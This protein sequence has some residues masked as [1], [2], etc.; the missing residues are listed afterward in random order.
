[1]VNQ[2]ASRKWPFYLRHGLKWVG[3]SILLFIPINFIFVWPILH[4][5]LV[6]FAWIGLGVGSIF[7]LMGVWYRRK[8]Q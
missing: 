2:N 6:F 3:Y 8:A 7:L 5:A 4:W 1:M